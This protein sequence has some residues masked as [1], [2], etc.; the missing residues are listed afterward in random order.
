VKNSTEDVFLR[1]R[2]LRGSDIVPNVARLCAMNLYLHGVGTDPNHPPITIG[3]SLAHDLEEKVD[4]VVTNPPFGKKSSITAISDGKKMGKD[5]ITYDRGDFWATTSNKQ[6]NFVQHVYS[7]LKSGGRAAMVVPDNVL[8]EAGAG[9]K[10]RREL[11]ARVDVHTLLR[12]PT[13]IWYSTGVKANVL[14][15]DKRPSTKKELW[16]YDLRT[17]KNFTLRN[18][19]I[20]SED[21][22][23]FVECYN[24]DRREKRKESERFKCYSYANILSSNKASLDLISLSDDLYSD[25]HSLPSHDVL[26][27]E[28]IALLKEATSEFEAA[29]AAGK[30]RRKKKK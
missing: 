2:A 17:N 14:F 22:K 28:V 24:S 19:P 6:L 25:P 15:F 30:S 4:M 11:L 10:I 27:A 12:L 16:I 23:D 5:D 3:D 21:L 18:K 8:F 1:T 29:M 13:G 7:M 26:A 20:T 9:E